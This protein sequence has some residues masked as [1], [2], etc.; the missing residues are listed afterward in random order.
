MKIRTKIKKGFSLVELLV[1]IAVLAVLIGLLAGGGSTARKKGKI[2]STKAM[3][4]SLETA[5]A[6]YHS[7]YGQYPVSGNQNLVNRLADE[8]TY[9]QGGTAPEADWKGP[10][11]SFKNEDL[12]GSIPAAK[13]IDA[14][15]KDFQYTLNVNKYS[16]VSGGPDGDIGT[17]GDNIT[18][19]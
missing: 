19:E 5:L 10:Y 4:A 2:Y 14:W 13:V 8:A 12:N 18:S 9:G 3:I 16:I 15:D 11:I 17:T 6:M 1:V 7:D